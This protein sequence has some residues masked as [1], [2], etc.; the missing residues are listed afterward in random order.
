MTQEK[1]V[2]S[3]KS[4]T[5]G[6]LTVRRVLPEVHQSQDDENAAFENFEALATKLVRVPKEEAVQQA[7]KR[8][9]D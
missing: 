4:N 2:F 5:E 7:R 3:T 8:K 9:Q 6:R 1:L